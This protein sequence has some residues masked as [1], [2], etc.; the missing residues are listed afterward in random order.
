MPL[1]AGR[2]FDSRDTTSSQEVAIVNQEFSRKFLAGASPIGKHIRLEVGPGEPQ[3]VAQIIGMVKDSKYQSLREEFKP[4][5]FFA[6][7]QDKEPGQGLNVLIR[8]HLPAGILTAN[9]QKA[10]ARTDP[11][12]SIA[13]QAFQI[14]I[15]E[16][17]LKERL[18]AT[19]SGFFGFLA[20]TLA[21]IGLY[22]VISYMV[23]RRRS[24][25]GIRMA[26]GAT[27][28][29]VLRLI[30]KEA[31]I[32]VVL[33]L[34]V[35]SGLAIA[36]GRAAGTLLYGLQ[37]TDPATLALAVLLLASIA[38]LAS[39]LPA[40]RAALTEPMAALREE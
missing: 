14:Q 37:A 5:V 17:L 38:M 3:H 24:E 27:R 34:F 39:F 10:A 20:A 21:T 15:Q 11:G 12:I 29:G 28:G 23:A 13:F 25:I 26:L 31:G 6:Q 7:S 32:L 30:L 35:G 8:S 4:I 19:L 18:M 9:L 40:R 2:D 36:A 16:S 22:G 1:L 33:G